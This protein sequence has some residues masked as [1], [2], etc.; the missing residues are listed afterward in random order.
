MLS[1]GGGAEVGGGAVDTVGAGRNLTKLSGNIPR[2]PFRVPSHH[3]SSACV[4]VCVS[5]SVCVCVCVCVR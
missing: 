2:F 4:C 3:P 1:T 5:V